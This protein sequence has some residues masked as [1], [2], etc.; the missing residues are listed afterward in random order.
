MVIHSGTMSSHALNF[1][2]PTNAPTNKSG[3][4]AAKTNWK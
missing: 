2:R 1:R 4:I 3:V